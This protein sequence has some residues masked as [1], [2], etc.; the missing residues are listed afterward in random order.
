MIAVEL[1]AGQAHAGPEGSR[2][3]NRQGLEDRDLTAQAAAVAATSEPMNP[4][5]TTTTRGDPVVSAARSARLSSSVRSVWTP[6]SSGW[7]GRRRTVAPVAM[8]R[9]S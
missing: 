9:P 2:Q 3:R 5:P 7:S 4:A 8:T 1:G 6:S